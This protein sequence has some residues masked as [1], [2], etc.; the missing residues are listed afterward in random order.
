MEA[1]LTPGRY[2]GAGAA[3]PQ[4]IWVVIAAGATAWLSAVTPSAARMVAARPQR[5]GSQPELTPRH[6]ALGLRGPLRGMR[7]RA[8]LTR[9]GR[10]RRGERPGDGPARPSHPRRRGLRVVTELLGHPPRATLLTE[11][12]GGRRDR[13]PDL[14]AARVL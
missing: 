4:H 9:P 12:P 2:T 14:L 3:D 10:S 13:L 5:R 8:S 11:P 7:A 6:E 1:R